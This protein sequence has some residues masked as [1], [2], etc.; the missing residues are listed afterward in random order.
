MKPA[1][2]RFGRRIAVP[3]TVQILHDYRVF[4]EDRAMRERCAAE[5]GLPATATW[6]DIVAHRAGKKRA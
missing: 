4:A 1:I 3:A 5:D 6:D 2:K